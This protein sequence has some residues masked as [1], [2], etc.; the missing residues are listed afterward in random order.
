MATKFQP[1]SKRNNG[2]NLVRAIHREVDFESSVNHE[3]TDTSVTL[4]EDFSNRSLNSVHF[5]PKVCVAQPNQKPAV[6]TQK[7]GLRD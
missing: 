4:A 3:T 7:R 5:V 1:R 6:V 2:G